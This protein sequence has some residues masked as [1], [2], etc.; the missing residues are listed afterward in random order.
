MSEQPATTQPAATVDFHVVQSHDFK[1]SYA[2]GIYSSVTPGGL[3]NLSFYVDRLPLPDLMTF[4]V[5]NN[6]LGPEKARSARNGIVREVQQGVLLD[7]QTVKN[8]I[9]SL[10]TMMTAFEAS[11]QH[12]SANN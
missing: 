3:I 6:T 9:N 5:E 1:T 12:E 10:Q 4:F 8:V 11:N 2:S 7:M